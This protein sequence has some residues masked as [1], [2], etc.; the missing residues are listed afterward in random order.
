[1]GFPSP[2]KDYEEDRLDLNTLL[3]HHPS[4]TFHMRVKTN[5]MEGDN[6]PEGSLAIVDRALTPRNND[7]IIAVVDGELIMRRLEQKG[8]GK[9]LTASNPKFKSI[10]IQK[11]LQVWGVVSVIISNPNN[12]SH[13]CLG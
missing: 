12:L 4:A 5:A 13:V 9:Y 7:I 11:Q 1:M 6:I 2:A 8:D 3:I 10:K